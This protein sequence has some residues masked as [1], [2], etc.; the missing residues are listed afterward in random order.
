MKR[1][2]GSAVWVS[3]TVHPVKNDEGHIISSLGMAVDITERKEAEARR[4]EYADELARSNA[5][6][7]QFAYVASHD[8][9]EP[10]R[11]V[12]SYTQ[13]LAKRYEGRL[14]EDADTYIEYA[15]VG[16]SGMRRI[17][18]D[19]LAYLRVGSRERPLARTNLNVIV[20]DALANL[21]AAIDD[22]NAAITV[23]SLPEVA[24][25]RSQMTQLF[26]NILGNAVK[27][28]SSQ[29]LR[30]H[31]SADRGDGEWTFSISDNGIGIDREFS[32][33]IFVI[34]N[35]LHTREEYDGTGIGIAICKKIV[36]RQG[37]RIWVESEIG[38]GC[39]FR[40]ILTFTEARE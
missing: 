12:S 22:S 2:D 35:K 30:V 16:A 37:G 23:D 24:C 17:I 14:D 6:L 32:D 18:Q 40:F 31:I 11:M 39:N 10:L 13:L 29:P 8:L 28:R 20:D 34:F 26:Q 36:E 5:D 25:D 4:K 9:Q 15:V 1:A 21:M 19:L 3:L 33:Q 7:Q 38:Q 27:Y